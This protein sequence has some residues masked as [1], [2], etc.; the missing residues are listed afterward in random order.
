MFYLDLKRCRFVQKYLWSIKLKNKTALAVKDALQSIF[1]SYSVPVSIQS[2]NSKEFKKLLLKEYLNSLNIRIIHERPRNPK[3]QGQVERVNQTVK[4]WLAKKLHENTGNR[5]I[6]LH[7]DVIF[8]YNITKHR[9]TAKSYF[10]ILHGQQSFNNPI[11]GGEFEDTPE[12]LSRS[13]LN[14]PN[15]LRN[16]SETR[17]I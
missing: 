1:R 14:L 16:D 17:E 7:E 12:G 15:A 6:D 2:D 4:R 9:A 5:W 8:G 13:D 11:N 10:L 3:A